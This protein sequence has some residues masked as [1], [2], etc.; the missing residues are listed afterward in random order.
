M[1]SELWPTEPESLELTALRIEAQK[2]HD[3]IVT[4]CLEGSAPVDTHL[5]TAYDLATSAA[6][7]RVA[8]TGRH[9]PLTYVRW[10]IFKHSGVLC[11][12][13]EVQRTSLEID[14]GSII[15]ATTTYPVVDGDLI[16]HFVRKGY[17]IDN[18][19]GW[20]DVVDP[21]PYVA[22]VV[23]GTTCRSLSEAVKEL[24]SEVFLSDSPTAGRR[25]EAGSLA[26]RVL[27]QFHRHTV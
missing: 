18:G 25:A 3:D 7:D 14:P 5:N 16:T 21:D 8:V 10:S 20:F 4:A 26:A 27:S 11:L 17:V 22:G 2:L 24:R 1:S 12:E 23:D 19:R 15:R 6:D 9:T 13:E